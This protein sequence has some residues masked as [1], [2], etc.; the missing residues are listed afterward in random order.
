MKRVK[1]LRTRLLLDVLMPMTVTWVLGTAVMVSVAY[2]FTQRAFDRALLDDAYLLASRVTMNHGVPVL[3]MTPGDLSTLLFDQRETEFFAIHHEDGRWIAGETGLSVPPENDD[4]ADIL[5]INLRFKGQDLRGVVLERDSPAPLRIVV[6]LTTRSRGQWLNRLLLFSVLPQVGL[7]MLLAVWLQRGIRRDLA[8]LS[9][10]Q[11]NVEQRDVA[12]LTPLPL[13]TTG[14]DPT[15]EVAALSGAINALLAR[16]DE[17]VR[18]QREFAGNVAHELRTPLAGIRAAAEYGVAQEEPQRWREQLLA[19]LHGQQRASH[20]VDQLLALALADEA[21]NSRVL[22]PLD[23]GGLAREV[24]LKFLARADKAGVDLG[25]SGLDLPVTVLAQ[26]AL[27]EGLLVNLL[28]NALRYGRPPAGAG[29]IN[30][31][32][33]VQPDGVWL[34]VTDNGPGIAP[35]QREALRQRG[36]QGA[37]GQRLGLGAGLGLA[38]VDRYAQLMRAELRL[39]SGKDGRGLR[40]S[41]V[42]PLSAQS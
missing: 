30:L 8:P 25:A 11:R 17:G 37:S 24:V 10:L 20:L 26:P 31:D 1:S 12:D 41:V 14:P 29:V 4:A 15:R 42:F 16:V 19:V 28:D 22:Q 33:A 3:S 6:A 27:V 32:L 9:A 21:R 40:A 2:F 5:F 7:L 38:I 36:V 18:A 39:D 23:L 34:S 35:A 13:P